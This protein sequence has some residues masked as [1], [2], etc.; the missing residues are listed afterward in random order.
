MSLNEYELVLIVRPDADDATVSELVDKVE[1]VISGDDG[2]ILHRDDWG[3]RKLAYPIAKHQKGHYFIIH[4]LSKP[5]TLV[6][7]ERVIRITEGILRFLAVKRTDAVDVEMRVK[8][9]AEQGRIREE[10]AKARAEAE[11]R[12][13][14]ARA[15]SEAERAANAPAPAPAP[16]A[17]TA[18]EDAGAP[19]GAE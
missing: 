6:E 11:A 9:A 16:A 18:N 12:A 13:A 17:E 10:E 19:A 2:H 5:S 4:N 8:E 7:V 1:A 3:Q 14:E 15:A